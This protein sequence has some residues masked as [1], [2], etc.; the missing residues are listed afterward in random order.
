M[1]K[2]VEFKYQRFVHYIHISHVTTYICISSYIICMQLIDVY[3]HIKVLCMISS[4][5][6]KKML[7][8]VI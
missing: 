8:I 4:L 7:F 1:Y 5:S 2:E 3:F 6:Y